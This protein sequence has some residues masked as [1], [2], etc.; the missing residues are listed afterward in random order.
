[1]GE[2]MLNSVAGFGVD[3]ADEPGEPLG[4][5]VA[6]PFEFVHVD[7]DAGE[8]HVGEDA[9]QRPFEVPIEV[10]Q[11]FGLETPV[12]E[13]G[14]LEGDLRVLRGVFGRFRDIDLEHFQLP[15]PGADERR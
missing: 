7:A 14:Q 1:M 15:L 5:L 13:V 12:D 8:L 11:P 4:Q 9:D 3:L 2:S 10:P 6:L